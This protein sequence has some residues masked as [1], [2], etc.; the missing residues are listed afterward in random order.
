MSALRTPSG[1]SACGC[2]IRV[3]LGVNCWRPRGRSRERMEV[4]SFRQSREKGWKVGPG[5]PLW[6]GCFRINLAHHEV[7]VKSGQRE[8]EQGARRVNPAT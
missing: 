6:G 7:L 1:L 5:Q 8:V 3:D 4:G 2:R